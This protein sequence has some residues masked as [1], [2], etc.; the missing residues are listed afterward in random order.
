MSNKIICADCDYIAKTNYELER[1]LESKSHV[2]MMLSKIKMQFET[3]KSKID[4]K[5]HKS[6]EGFTKNYSST[7]DFKYKQKM[8]EKRQKE[9]Y[10]QEKKLKKE[11]EKKLKKELE[12]KIKMEL[13]Q[14]LK[15]KKIAQKALLK[16]EKK[17]EK[18]IIK[19]RKT[20]EKQKNKEITEIIKQKDNEIRKIANTFKDEQINTLK[21]VCEKTMSTAKYIMVHFTKAPI[22]T[23]LKKNKIR[24]ML[25]FCVDKNKKLVELKTDPVKA[26]TYAYNERSLV[27]YIG[28]LIIQEFGTMDPSNRKFHSTDASRLTF[29]VRENN[30]GLSEWVKD[31]E[32]KIIIQNVIKPIILEIASMFQEYRSS[33]DIDKIDNDNDKHNE[34][35]DVSNAYFGIVEWTN[36][37]VFYKN[38][39]QYITPSFVFNKPIGEIDYDEKFPLLENKK[40]F[41]KRK[42]LNNKK[43]QVIDSDSESS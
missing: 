19:L 39:L 13:K 35:M 33:F 7:E 38:I 4:Y 27:K 8:E 18:E 15:E 43:K 5:Y 9:K 26:I 22:L 25:K 12:K 1:H 11:Q 6:I 3:E 37:Q 42:E 40:R 30:D 2:E 34:F 24:H 31:V 14:K 28:N 21:S 16:I 36:C 41:V 10:E 17:K 32:G 29:I 20:L 23:K